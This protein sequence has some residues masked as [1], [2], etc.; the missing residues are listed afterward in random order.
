[1][2]NLL[3]DIEKL[4]ADVAKAAAKDDTDLQQKMDALKL[5]QPY[6][7][8]MRK[9]RG[10]KIEEDE[11]FDEQPTMGEMQHRLRVVENDE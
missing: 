9:A 8:V 11:A 2:T 10:G 1:M 6:Y 5:L 4:V 7:A 3:S